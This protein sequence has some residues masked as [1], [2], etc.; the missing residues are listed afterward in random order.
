MVIRAG[1]LFL[2]LHQLQLVNRRM[3]TATYLGNTVPTSLLTEVWVSQPKYSEQ[4]RA[5]PITH[6]PCG[7]MGSG[8]FCHTHPSMTEVGMRTGTEVT[9]A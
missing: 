8:Q 3:G 9:R 7:S 2:T 5:M 1:E 6:L 4:G